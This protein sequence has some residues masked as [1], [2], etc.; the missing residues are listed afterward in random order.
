MGAKAFA[1]GS[2]VAF[3]GSPDLHTTAHEAAHVVQQRGGGQLAGGVGQSGDRYEQHADAVAD[4]VVAGRPAEGLLDQMAGGGS[5]SGAVQHLRE[6]DKLAELAGEEQKLSPAAR[7]AGERSLGAELGDVKVHEGKK[8][9]AAAA[10]MGA[11]AFTHGQ[12][13]VLGEGAENSLN[14]VM[15][16]EMAHTAQQKGAAKGV[17][18]KSNRVAQGSSLEVDADQAAAAI[19]QGRPANLA[20]KGAEQIACFEGGEHMQLGTEGFAKA[21]L[22]DPLTVG[23]VKAEAGLFTALQGDF[24]GGSWADLEADCNEKPEGVYRLFDVLKHEQGLRAAH[25]KYPWLNEEPDSD[26]AIIIAQMGL[27]AKYL[28]Y[29]SDN[30]THFGEKSEDAEKKFKLLEAD[31]PA[32]ASEIAFAQ[33]NFGANVA[34]Y[35]R[36]HIDALKRAFADAIGGKSP[37]LAL[38]MDAGA[39][40]FLTDAFASGH[41]RTPRDAMTKEYH[42]VFQAKGRALVDQFIDQQIP[43]TVDVPAALGLGGVEA[44]LPDST[45]PPPINLASVKQHIKAALYPKMDGIM[46]TI[47]DQAA[48]FGAKQLHDADNKGGL[49]VHNN[50]H[51]AWTATG[52]HALSDEK[53]NIKIAEMAV[54]ASASHTKRIYEMSL[55]KKSD[56]TGGTPPQMPFL[57]MKPIFDLLPIVDADN[58]PQ[59]D[60]HWESASLWYKLGIINNLRKSFQGTIE[61]ATDHI[62]YLVQQA[63]SSALQQAMSALGKAGQW[64]MQHLQALVQWIAGKVPPIPPELLSNTLML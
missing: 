12:D 46:S 1:T 29:A 39:N 43:E 14:P 49:K 48:N 32:Y 2:H 36:L 45:K 33:A 11:K 31:N 15:A 59:Q 56:K 22:V 30:A 3:R 19:L 51:M 41:M 13:I 63:A 26:G 35:I 60:W 8:S 55:S 25:Y 42:A 37:D 28:T 7:M 20:Q 17:A 34:E 62:N 24:Y 10:A 44:L 16:H 58:A 38:A 23:K 57:S 27:R 4:A 9:A 40:H 54:A 53:Q 50:A 47:A 18:Q 52:D 61:S 21:G 5:S 64:L 6:E